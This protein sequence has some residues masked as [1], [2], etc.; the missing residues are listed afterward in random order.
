[1]VALTG[2]CAIVTGAARGLGRAFAESL[3]AAGVNVTLCDVQP[4]V[5]AAARALTGPGHAIGVV[6]D[7]ARDADVVR[8]VDAAVRAFGR[9]D[10][11]IDNAAVWRY[12]PVTDDFTKALDDWDA[13]MATNLRGTLMLSRACVPHIIAAGGGDIVLVG[14][15]DVLPAK[16]VPTNPADTDLYTASTWALNGFVQAWAL[17]LARKRVRVNALCV[18][19]TETPMLREQIAAGVAADGA[20]LQSEAVAALLIALLEE[21][22]DGRTGE[23][24]GVWPGETIALGPRPPAHRTVTG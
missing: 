16:S 20:R 17:V 8:L 23:N 1:M 14:S 11:L 2:R 24:V 9:V 10:T 21:G 22:A 5:T 18:G 3:V 13:I 7:I 6:A 4:E 19:P 12:T 15:A